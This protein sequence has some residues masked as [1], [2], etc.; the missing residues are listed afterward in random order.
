MFRFEHRRQKLASRAVFLQRVG[1]SL[2]LALGA[3]GVSLA[4]GIAG[5]MGLAGLSFVDAFL[6]AAMILGGMGP[7]ASL[8]SDGA[9]VF[10]GLYALYSGLL[11]IAVTG[12]VL[13]PVLHRVLHAIHADET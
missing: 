2:F 10:A 8:D 11:F 9:K 4:F 7:V 12:V 1:W 5:Y 13:A 3:I 6:N